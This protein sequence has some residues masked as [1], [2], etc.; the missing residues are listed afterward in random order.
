MQFAQ[1]NIRQPISECSVVEDTA[2]YNNLVH[3]TDLYIITPWMLW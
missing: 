1:N 3:F 2:D